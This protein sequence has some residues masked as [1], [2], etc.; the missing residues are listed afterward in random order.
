M[1]AKTNNTAISKGNDK[2]KTDKKKEDKHSPALNIP[3]ASQPARTWDEHRRSG[4]DTF[5]I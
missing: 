4:S 1:S 3:N 5:G 2:S